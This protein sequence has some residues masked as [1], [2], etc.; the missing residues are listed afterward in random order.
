[1]DSVLLSVA[2]VS[3]SATDLDPVKIAREVIACERVGAGMVHLHARDQRGK[4]TADLTVLE[5][6]LRLIRKESNIIIEAS[7]GGVSELSIEERCAPLAL[8]QVECASLNVGSVNL[9]RM[10]YQNSPEDVEYCVKQI[11]SAGK[12][13]EV[14]VFEIGMIHTTLSLR[15][16]FKL[17]PPLLLSIVL[18]HEGAAPATIKALAAL[19]SFVPDDVLWGVTHY[20]RQSS[21]VISAAVAMGACT[22]RVG[23]EDSAVID[24]GR[25]AQENAPI[26]GHF[27]NL[28][29][30]MGKRA[31]L[32]DE[33][34]QMLEIKLKSF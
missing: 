9:G 6:T 27:K 23:F 29:Q 17:R 3:A 12:I 33:A 15:E 8:P 7:T 5:E 19:Q 30:S 22:V 10:I 26:V 31:M 34:R 25:V 14:E 13:P 24:N 32:P 1:M 2:P 21:D 16:K 4:L 11:L 20:G 18:G 28:L